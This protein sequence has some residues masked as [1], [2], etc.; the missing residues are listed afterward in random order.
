VSR[1]SS[2]TVVPSGRHIKWICRS[3]DGGIDAR[4]RSR[5]VARCQSDRVDYLY[6]GCARAPRAAGGCPG[7]RSEGPGTQ[8]I[9]RYVRAVYAGSKRIHPEVAADIA[10]HLGSDV[11]RAVRSMSSLQS[12]PESQTRRW[13]R[14]ASGKRLSRC[15][16]GDP[17][18]TGCQRSHPRGDPRAQAWNHS[19][20]T[21]P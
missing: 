19:P 17:G 11:L 4:S 21:L 14:L 16:S 12:P 6:G 1:R 9:A 13:I 8:G 3:E 10:S 20:I 2:V 7:V 5:P 15:T 18:Q